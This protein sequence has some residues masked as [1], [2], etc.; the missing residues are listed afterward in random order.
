MDNLLRLMGIE[1]KQDWRT[2]LVHEGSEN[3]TDIEQ[4]CKDIGIPVKYDIVSSKGLRFEVMY[5]FVTELLLVDL[6]K[7]L[8]KKDLMT[9]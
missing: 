6:V 3:T 7:L 9:L 8:C 2:L 5:V 1:P 4:V